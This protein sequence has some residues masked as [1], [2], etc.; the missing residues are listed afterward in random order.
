MSTNDQIWCMEAQ[1]TKLFAPL[2]G[3]IDSLQSEITDLQD[4]IE[5]AQDQGVSSYFLC[6]ELFEKSDQLE[7][8]I[9]FKKSR[10]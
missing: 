3:I 9:I 5:R 6:T 10:E 4:K 7:K 8:L 2:E 1:E